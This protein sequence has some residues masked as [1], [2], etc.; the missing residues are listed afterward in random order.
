MVC[1]EENENMMNSLEKLGLTN[2]RDS[3]KPFLIPIKDYLASIDNFKLLSFFNI[4]VIY[5]TTS[6]KFVINLV[7][8]FTLRRNDWIS[9]LFMG[10]HIFYM[11]TT[12]FGS[13]LIPSSKVTWPRRF[14]SFM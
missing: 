6:T 2:T 10:R 11:A 13:I 12:L 4:L 3:F 1:S 5:F 7:K 14:P 9:F 8:K